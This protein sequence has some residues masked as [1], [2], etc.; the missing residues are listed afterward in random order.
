MS[1]V[2]CP[3][4]GHW[5]STLAHVC[6]ACCRAI[7]LA[8]KPRL[9]VRATSAVVTPAAGGVAVAD[10]G[11]YIFDAIRCPYCGTDQAPPPKHTGAPC[12]ACGK[13]LAIARSPDGISSIVRWGEC[14]PEKDWAEYR[15]TRTAALRHDPAPLK[16][17][18]ARRLHRYA[19]LGLWVRIEVTSGGCHSCRRIALETYSAAYPPVLPNPACA[20]SFCFCE[21]RPVMPKQ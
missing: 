13:K 6:P 1:F 20:N 19:E 5:V 7:G 17:M 2:A 4:C 15:A 18:N 8:E 21:Y 10:P 12:R 14:A 9:V 16:R 11:G 3:W